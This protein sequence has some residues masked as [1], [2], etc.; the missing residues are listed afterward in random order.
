MEMDKLL[1]SAQKE[2]GEKARIGSQVASVEACPTGVP[3]L[4]VAL[5]IGGW[6]KGGLSMVFGPKS[7]GK[8]S[9]TYISVAEFQRTHEDKFAAIIDLEGSFDPDWVKKLGVDPDNVLILSPYSGEEAMKNLIWCSQ[10]EELGL[11]IF[12][13]IGAM[14]SERELEEDGKKQAYGQSGLITDMV[15]KAGPRF[16]ASDR[17]CVLINQVRDTA[18]MRN[19]PMVHA[20]GGHALHHAC[21]VIIQMRPGNTKYMTKNEFGDEIQVG[22]R[23]VL[24]INQSKIG[25]PK[26][27]AEYDFYWE[28]SA[29]H[30]SGIDIEE[31]LITSAIRIGVVNRQVSMYEFEDEKIR[32]RENFFA[33]V[34]EDPARF[35]RLRDQFYQKFEEIRS[36]TPNE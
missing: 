8:S 7:S 1:V 23:P 5:G 26:R 10:K 32:G 28:D 22:Y 30:K 18:N 34:R 12:D 31:S 27:N 4:D 36:G 24:T 9:L 15:K 3:S 13:S 6:P 17:V 35:E 14:A 11:V 2:F 29:L 21:A 20:P 25:P 33:W 19:L 16:N